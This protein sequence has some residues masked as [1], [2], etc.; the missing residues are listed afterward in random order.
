MKILDFGIAKVGS[1]TK[2]MTRAGSV[3]GTPHYMCP[4]QAAGAAVDHRT[5]IYALGVILYE[6]ASGKVP[7]RRRQLHGDPHAAHVQG[8]GPHPR[9]RARGRRPAGARRDRPQVP[10]EEARG[11]LRGDGRARR[12]SREARARDLAR[13]GRRDDGALG[14]LQRPGRLLPVVGHAG[15]GARVAARA[16]RSAGRSTR[17]SP[18]WR[19]SWGSSASSWRGA[20]TA[21]PRRH[22]RGSS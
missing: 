22:P 16:P 1:A 11:P 8:A 5:D 14:R 21:R 7:V 20:R 17:R 9:A 19:R 15:A 3:F 10:D 18:R 4:E 13:R 6:M 2:K 12:R